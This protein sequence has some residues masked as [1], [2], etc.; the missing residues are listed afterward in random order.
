MGPPSHKIPIPF[1]YFKGFSWECYGS[2]GMWVPLF[3]VPGT[4]LDF[5]L[6]RIHGS[7]LGYSPSLIVRIHGSQLGHGFHVWI[8]KKIWSGLESLWIPTITRWTVRSTSP[9]VSNIFYVHPYLGKI[10]ILT[11]IF[12]RGWNHRLDTLAG[13]LVGN[14]PLGMGFW[15]LG[16]WWLG[17]WGIMDPTWS[18]K[19]IHHL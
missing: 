4:L 1:P 15:P 10:P 14:D 9:V 19:V 5:W 7:Q 13:A 8:C 11:N 16:F 12:Q 3:G 18:S 2:M 6:I 17:P